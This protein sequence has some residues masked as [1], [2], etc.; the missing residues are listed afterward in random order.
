MKDKKLILVSNDDGVDAKGLKHLIE[1]AKKFGDVLVAA[2]EREQSGKSH[3]INLGEPLRVRRI[4]REDGVKFFAIKGTPV[5]CVKLAIN[6][7]VPRK[8]DIMLSGINHGSNSAVN[9]IYSGT[10]GAAI[11]A[12]LYGIPAI[13][14]SL[15]DHSK[16]A[17]FDLIDEN[18]DIIIKDVLEN[19]LPYQ[20]SLN[21]NYPVID[22][23]DFKGYKI[24]TQTKGV[25]K[26]EYEKRHDPYGR[27]YYWLTGEFTNHQ[28]DNPETDEW[29]LKN[30]YAAI[31][32]T[33]IDFTEYNTIEILK[34]RLK[35]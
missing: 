29:A 35:V 18:A 20:V 5:D 1:I 28:L 3:S 27:E 23:K 34:S 6:Q 9:V 7:L 17:N 8:P 33:K 32:P 21:I 25:W 13:G 2:P 10:M 24:C 15:L 19:G 31:V 4:E 11:E 26:E 30:N 14:F 16:D 12:S 22:K